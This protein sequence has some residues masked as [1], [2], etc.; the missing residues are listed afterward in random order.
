MWMHSKIGRYANR[1][2]T[3]TDTG[4]DLH[5]DTDTDADI[6]IDVVMHT[7]PQHYFL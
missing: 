7:N 5:I 3:D 1:Y 4:I 2:N 6:D